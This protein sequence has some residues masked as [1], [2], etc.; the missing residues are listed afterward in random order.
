[1]EKENLKSRANKM[2]V[3]KFKSR[4]IYWLK[5]KV[6]QFGETVKQL[7]EK[8]MVPVKVSNSKRTKYLLQTSG[9]HFVFLTKLLEQIIKSHKM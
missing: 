5:M 4:E 9:P 7:V 2:Y 1:M 8:R 6:K 3:R